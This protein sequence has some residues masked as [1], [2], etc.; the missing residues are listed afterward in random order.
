MKKVF[1]NLCLI[2]LG[3]LTYSYNIHA[4]D[5]SSSLVQLAEKLHCSSS[6]TEANTSL[7]DIRLSKLASFG[8][9]FDAFVNQ[10]NGSL[11]IATLDIL[12]RTMDEAA[13]NFPNLRSSVDSI[14]A[15]WN[16]CK[17]S[18]GHVLLD[19]NL[20]NAKLERK[21]PGNF[22]P[23][24]KEGLLR[25][26]FISTIP[27]KHK[28]LLSEEE[29]ANEN[30]TE[31]SAKLY[32][33]QCLPSPLN[34]NND[35]SY[36][37][38]GSLHLATLPPS[39]PEENYL[40]QW[41]PGCEVELG[42]VDGYNKG[43]EAGLKSISGSKTIALTTKLNQ[44]NIEDPKRNLIISRAWSKEAYESGVNTGLALGN[45]AGILAQVELTPVHIIPSSGASSL[46]SILPNAS[47]YGFS[48]SY[49]HSWNLKD[50]QPS[51]G[52]NISFTPRDYWFIRSGLNLKYAGVQSRPT[53][54]WG[55]GYDDWHAGS[56]GFQINNWGPIK[57]DSGLQ[58]EKATAAVTYKF[59][60]MFLQSNNIS[61]FAALTIP[62]SNAEPSLQT[63]LRWAPIPNWYVYTGVDVPL[64]GKIPTWS[65][66]FG[67][68]DYRPFTFTIQY[69]NYGPNNVLRD[70]FST[71]GV[72]TIG[73]SWAL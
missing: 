69:N 27:G 55:V 16:Y 54:S 37:S 6:E 13:T 2:A 4:G 50:G 3:T 18:Q 14:A 39:N 28:N 40:F 41:N 49:Y 43:Y 22:Y 15:S 62:V 60:S 45:K 24:N 32:A 17:I 19:L 65:Y 8:L 67:R 44:K 12:L 7:N 63:S 61:A 52:A 25:W 56:F 9:P 11:H 73:G 70:N 20:V 23:A 57:L 21:A 46:L 66:G 35:S 48:G 68:Q 1:F 47:A 58:F 64:G 42:E 53:Y 72:L 71:N 33:A 59:D 29:H 26:G 5:H 10:D 30:F 36:T 31:S 34:I 38:Y 51:V